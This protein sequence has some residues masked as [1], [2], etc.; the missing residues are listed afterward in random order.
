LPSQGRSRLWASAA[1]LIAPDHMICDALP[2]ETVVVGYDGQERSARVLERAIETVKADGGKLIVVVAEE[3][4]PMQYASPA[5]FAPSDSG[6]YEFRPPI[7]L[8]DLEHPLGGVQEIIE[9][10]RKRLDE[11]EVS[12]VCVWGVGDPAQVIVDAATEHG[13]SMIMIGAH[14]HGF[15]GRLFGEDVDGE[16]QRAAQC[17]VV[18]V[19]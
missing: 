17:A 12:A 11:A 3:L 10:A 7:E 9:R 4:P 5:G 18:L 6:L 1:F 16:V 8:P 2:M 14:H 19:E 15:F 13:A